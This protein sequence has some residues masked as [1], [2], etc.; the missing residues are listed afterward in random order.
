MRRAVRLGHPDFG[1][2]FACRCTEDER[3]DERL[4]RLQRYSNLGPLARLTFDN[5]SPRGRSPDPRHQERFA[6]AVKAG[7]RFAEQPS[8][9]LGLGPTRPR[10]DVT[11]NDGE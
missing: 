1:R 5:L 10:R 6:E 8:G 2:A 7:L 3:E 11:L 4:A 9:W